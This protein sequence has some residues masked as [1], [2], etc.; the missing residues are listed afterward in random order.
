MGGAMG[1]GRCFSRYAVSFVIFTTSFSAGQS[2]DRKMLIRDIATVE[3]IRNNSLIG[4]GL[5]VGLARHRR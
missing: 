4:Y 5:V 2:V 3:G 1:W